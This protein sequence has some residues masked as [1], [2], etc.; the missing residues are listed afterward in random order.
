MRQHPY[1]STAA[2]TPAEA[3]AEL[4]ARRD[5]YT[6]E[7]ERNRTASRAAYS[8]SVDH[9]AAG[10]TD[11]ATLN[12]RA[13]A[14]AQSD[15]HLAEATASAYSDAVNIMHAALARADELAEL[16][17]RAAV[18]AAYL[19]AGAVRRELADAQPPADDAARRAL[20]DAAIA[21]TLELARAHAADHYPTAARALYEHAYE[22]AEMSTDAY[23]IDRTT[24]DA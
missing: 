22:L 20:L 4:T 9:I 11:E 14:A 15:A 23:R 17:E 5:H 3:V 2:M 13:G 12:Q 10:R 24:D 7:A 19:A 16:A 18:D 6:A 8:R 1:R 21:S